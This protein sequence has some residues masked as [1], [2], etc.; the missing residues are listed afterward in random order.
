MPAQSR[1]A[2]PLIIAGSLGLT[3]EQPAVLVDADAAPSRV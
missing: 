3:P 1:F 2:V